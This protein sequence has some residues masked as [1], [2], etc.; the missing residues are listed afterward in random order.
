VWAWWALLIANTLAYG[1]AMTYDRM[2]GF[3]GTNEMLEYVCLGWAYA[4]LAVTAPF[5]ALALNSQADATHLKGRSDISEDWSASASCRASRSRRRS[6]A[7]ARA[8]PDLG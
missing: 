8:R 5:R 1:S 3:I 6:Q 4:A 2:V 7:I